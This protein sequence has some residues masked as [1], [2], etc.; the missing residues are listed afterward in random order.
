MTQLGRDRSPRNQ[1][2]CSGGA[3]GGS[4][5][6]DEVVVVVVNIEGTDGNC[7]AIDNGDVADGMVVMD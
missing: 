4:E 1:C 2:H 7:A 5:A 3:A 6:G